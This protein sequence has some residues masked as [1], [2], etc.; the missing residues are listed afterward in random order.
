MP[1]LWTAV[2]EA[3]ALGG[4]RVEA[5]WSKALTTVTAVIMVAEAAG[6]G[7][8]AAYWG[9]IREK[10]AAAWGGGVQCVRSLSD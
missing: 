6:D 9:S 1:R 8:R 5:R 3:F 2:Q 10:V 4:A 7:E